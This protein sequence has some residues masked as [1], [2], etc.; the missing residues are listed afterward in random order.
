MSS[1]S[2]DAGAHPLV[3][4][5]IPTVERLPYLEE[6]LTSVI[7]Q[8]AT[9]WELVV[10]ENSGDPAYA[11]DVDRLV[12]R[13][14]SGFPNPVHVMHQVTQLSM[15]GHAN[16]LLARASGDY[17]L[18]LPDDDR[19]QPKCLQLLTTLAC[20]DPCADIVFCDHWII[21]G[22]GEID[23]RLAESISARYGRADL[24]PGRIDEERL[25]VLALRGSF[26]LQATLIRSQVLGH[27]PFTAD[28]TRLPDFDLFLR[29]VR[30]QSPLC[31]KYS[32]E[33]LVEYRVHDRQFSGKLVSAEQGVEFHEQFLA[34]LGPGNGLSREAARLHRRMVTRHR[35]A[36]AGQYARS[37]RWRKWWRTSVTT[38]RNDP[39]WVPSYLS[40]LRPVIS[41][42]LVAGVRAMGRLIISRYHVRM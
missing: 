1:F 38:I 8:T 14:T 4:I 27:T 28:A 9:D 16:A 41:A 42:R 36:L 33:R 37:R 24:R 40:L 7:T 31:V 12:A 11:T 22:E 2:A 25:I 15:V 19:L 17:V 3:S 10:G 21:N 30:G 13:L 18:Y 32:S 6:A 39:L 35:S 34:S 5:C 26:A 29:L 20:A 23:A